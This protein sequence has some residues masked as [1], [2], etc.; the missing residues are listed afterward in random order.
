[1]TALL[2]RPSTTIKPAIEKEPPAPPRPDEKPARLVSLDAYRGFIMLFMASSGFALATVAKKM[3][4]DDPLWRFLAFHTDHAEWVGG[5]LWD[6]IQPAFMFMVGVAMPYSYASRKAKGTSETVIW[7]HAAWRALLLVVLAV[8][9]SSPLTM[10]INDVSGAAIGSAATAIASEP[11]LTNV[12]FPNVL[13]QI[14]LGYLFVFLFRG[15][16]LKV[17]LGALAAVLVGSWLLFFLYPLPTE[18]FDYG[19]VGVPAD[20]QHL[21][22]WFAHWDK[23]TNAAAAIDVWFLNLFPRRFAFVYNV[24]GYATLNF[25]PS[26]ATTLLGLMTGEMLRGPQ[27]R[28]R[29][30]AILLIGGGVC[31]LLGLLAGEFVCPIVK[32]IWTPSWALY[33][34][35]WVLLMLAAFYGV[36]DI[37]GWKRWAFP[38]TIVGMNSIAI[39][40]MSQ[41][42]RGFVRERLRMH[43]D[44]A[45]FKGMYEPIF[46][47]TWFGSLYG[48]IFETAGILLVLWLIC[49][50]MY[51]RGIF[52]RI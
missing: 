5:G 31:L 50:W 28:M 16:G 43:I 29:K 42:M 18:G 40:C 45:W 7:F 32:R 47:P 37:I 41:L 26:M 1:M 44:P 46:E 25:L 8:F 13:A 19:S 35:G 23:N 2:T 3:P 11:R 49:W 33:S 17:Q 22:G 48:P 38:L 6:M 24:G 15:R 21:P 27:S 14:G 12:E 39:Y 52:L 36:I 9:L 30:F 20:W 10:R 34:S 51:R 4:A